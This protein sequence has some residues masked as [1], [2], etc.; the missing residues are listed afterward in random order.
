MKVKLLKN[1]FDPEGALRRP[2]P[3]GTYVPARFEKVLP[4]TAEI[5]SRDRVVPEEGEDKKP[6]ANDEG[7]LKNAEAGQD[8]RAEMDRLQKLVD[9]GQAS[10]AEKHVLKKLIEKS[11]PPK[12]GK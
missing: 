9:A 12:E 10:N 3:G 2:Q 8:A 4:K 11:K 6:D 5:L 1:W 7:L